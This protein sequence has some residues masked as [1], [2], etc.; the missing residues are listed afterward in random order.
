MLS[1]QLSS[2]QPIHSYPLLSTPT[3]SK[4]V[5]IHTQQTDSRPRTPDLNQAPFSESPSSGFSLPRASYLGFQPVLFVLQ[6]THGRLDF[7]LLLSPYYHLYLGLVESRSV[8]P[9]TEMLVG[10]VVCVRVLG[11]WLMDG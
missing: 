10:S 9:R 8:M 3:Q 5:N 4:S 1:D 2:V 11:L 6:R 7:H